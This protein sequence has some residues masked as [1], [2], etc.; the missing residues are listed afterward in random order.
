MQYPAIMQPTHARWEPVTS[1]EDTTANGLMDGLTINEKH[2]PE[3]LPDANAQTSSIFSPVKPAH[4]RNFLIVDTVYENPPYSH[5]GVPGPNGQ[6][7]DTSFN[8]LAAVSDEIKDLLPPSCREAFDAAL[9][10]EL[11]WKSRWG[12]EAQDSMRKPPIIDKGLIL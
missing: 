5:L 8:G 11:E 9:A 2:D 6:S 3:K 4:A 12:T 10:K 1:M 7:L